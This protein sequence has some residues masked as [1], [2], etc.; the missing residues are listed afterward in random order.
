[1]REFTLTDATDA[2]AVRVEIADGADPIETAA[3]LRSVAGELEG[4]ILGTVSDCETKA[5]YEWAGKLP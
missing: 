2:P 5:H 1:M 3:F 4:G